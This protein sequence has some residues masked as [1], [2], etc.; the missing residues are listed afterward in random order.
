[1]IK[2]VG[3]VTSC[4]LT[5]A[6]RAQTDSAY[7]ANDLIKIEQSLCDALPGD[8][9]TWSIYL[10]PHWWAVT[11]EG[12]A[13]DKKTF[14]EE[15]TPFPKGISGNIHVIH[16]VCLFHDSTA[17]VHYTAD[18]FENVFGQK[19]HTTYAVMDTWYKT[20]H[21]WK[22]IG[23]QIFEI[24]Q[25]P[26]AAPSV[27]AEVRAFT[28]TYELASNRIAVISLKGDS[29]F[30]QKNNQA[31]EVLFQEANHIFFTLDNP[32]VRIFFTKNMSGI[33]QMRERRNG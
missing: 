7:K 10:D 21:S 8:S 13:Y 16:P 26:L 18:E 23:M 3:F 27:A 19:L 29:L 33:M 24:P 22:M 4:F 30:I 14:L 1:M 25:L 32:R 17:I 9:S 15:F 2:L 31:R 20:G 6:T 11:E 5:F 12:K 28:G